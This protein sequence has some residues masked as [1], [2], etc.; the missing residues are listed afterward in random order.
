MKEILEKLYAFTELKMIDPVVRFGE[1]LV[2]IP[3]LRPLGALIG[4]GGLA[5]AWLNLNGFAVLG[6]ILGLLG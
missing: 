3:V 5:A 4:F 2:D 6:G 1:N